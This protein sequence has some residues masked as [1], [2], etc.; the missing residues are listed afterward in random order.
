[1]NKSAI[2]VA[3]MNCVRVVGWT[4]ELYV[5]VVTYLAFLL[6]NFV[7]LMETPLKYLIVRFFKLFNCIRHLGSLFIV[8]LLAWKRLSSC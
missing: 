5:P 1:M 6:S 8:L 7:T 4:S 2:F 3:S